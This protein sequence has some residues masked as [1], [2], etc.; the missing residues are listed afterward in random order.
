MNKIAKYVFLLILVSSLAGCPERPPRLS[1][2]DT[3]RVKEIYEKNGEQRA[4][5]QNVASKKIVGDVYITD[6][7]VL[8]W[9]KKRI[10]GFYREWHPEWAQRLIDESNNK[11]TD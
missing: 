5:I 10:F 1:V 6:A 2:R 9:K 4:I 8:L 11:K 3:I 7:E